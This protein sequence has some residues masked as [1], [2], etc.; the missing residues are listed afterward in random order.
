MPSEKEIEVRRAE[1]ARRVAAGESE[2]DIARALGVSRTTVWTD[3]QVNAAAAK[4]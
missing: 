2:R 3:K 4:A 1:V